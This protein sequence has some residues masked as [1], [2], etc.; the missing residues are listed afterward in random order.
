MAIE[1]RPIKFFTP[2]DVDKLRV[3]AGGSPQTPNWVLTG[4]KLKQ[5]AD[6]LH[7]SFKQFDSA[8]KRRAL[9]NSAVPFVFIAKMYEDATAKSRRAEITSLFQM[10]SQNNVIGL[11]ASDELV[12]K[13]DSTSHMDKIS[14]RLVDFE[15]N[16]HAI[17]C[18]ETFREFQPKIESFDEE[19][20]Y[21]VKLIDFQ[22]YGLNDAM[23]RLFEQTLRSKGIHYKKTD[24]TS[25]LPVYKVHVTPDTF[26]DTLRGNDAYDMLFSIE[27]MP[28]YVVSLDSIQDKSNIGA[29]KPID[30]MRYETLGILDGGISSIPQL[31]PWINGERWTVYPA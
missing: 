21:K 13:I 6:I 10:N 7:Q 14:S 8:V 31:S 15:N 16:K 2:R 26:L 4:E 27:P 17:S 22:D 28:T 25:Q 30:G 20:S 11:T 12:V 3:E 9:R 1:K 19:S 23:Q 29:M 18:L 24:Y 5:R